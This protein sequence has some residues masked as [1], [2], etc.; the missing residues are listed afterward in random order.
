MSCICDIPDSQCRTIVSE[1]S[2]LL[3]FIAS[4]HRLHEDGCFRSSRR[5]SESV[6]CLTAG[7]LSSTSV[8]HGDALRDPSSV[9]QGRDCS[10]DGFCFAVSKACTY[11]SLTCFDR[12][13]SCMSQKWSS[14]PKIELIALQRLS[15]ISEHVGMSPEDIERAVDTCI[16][17]LKLLDPVLPSP[18]A[19]ANLRSSRVR[20]ATCHVGPT[21]SS[22][23]RKVV[24]C[25]STSVNNV[26]VMWS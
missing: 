6:S 2:C 23:F 20:I 12:A 26:A 1:T 19:M 24:L 25:S 7:F 9:A 21:V 16:E 8:T 4:V 5:G 17:D 13:P 15:Q 3:A 10:D 18:G 14:S 22:I 11:L